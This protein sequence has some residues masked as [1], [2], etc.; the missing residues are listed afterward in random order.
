MGGLMGGLTGPLM[1]DLIGDLTGGLTGDFLGTGGL[2]EVEWR[3]NS[4]SL[5]EVSRRDARYFSS[6]AALAAGETW[7]FNVSS[8]KNRRIDDVIRSDEFLLHRSQRHD[9]DLALAG[10]LLREH[11]APAWTKLGIISQTFN[12]V[13][14]FSSLLLSVALRSSRKKIRKKILEA[15]LPL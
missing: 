6:S 4:S 11:P 12:Y 3:P 8:N 5:L 1:G 15:N 2:E 9:G 7:T 14:L 13:S 10:F